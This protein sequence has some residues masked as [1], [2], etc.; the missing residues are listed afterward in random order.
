MRSWEI[1][2]SKDLRLKVSCG[3]FHCLVPLFHR[4][5]ISKPEPYSYFL[6]VRRTLLAFPIKI[7]AGHSLQVEIIRDSVQPRCIL[8][9]VVHFGDLAGA[10]SE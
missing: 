4:K 6:E 2:Q 10:V 1:F 9:D 3:L 5:D 8:L 7:L